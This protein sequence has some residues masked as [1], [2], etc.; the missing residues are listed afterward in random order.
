MRVLLAR[1]WCVM[2]VPLESHLL[3][4]LRRYVTWICEAFFN[5]NIIGNYLNSKVAYLNKLCPRGDKKQKHLYYFTIFSQSLLFAIKLYSSPFHLGFK[6]IT[7]LVV[8]IEH[9]GL[10]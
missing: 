2:R 7:H 8:G 3:S 4:I 6:Y 5:N 10:N 9:N 1:L